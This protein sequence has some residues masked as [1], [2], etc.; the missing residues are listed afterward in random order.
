MAANAVARPTQVA[1]RLRG[2]AASHLGLKIHRLHSNDL[3]ESELFTKL[4]CDAQEPL[5]SS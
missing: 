3:Y 4:Q 5:K 1:G 2:R